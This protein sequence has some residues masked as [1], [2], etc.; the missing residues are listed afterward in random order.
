MFKHRAT[1]W[2]RF[3][4]FP[5]V[6]AMAFT[7]LGLLACG[8]SPTNASAGS[9][10]EVGTSPGDPSG[11]STTTPGDPPGGSTATPPAPAQLKLLLTDAPVNDAEAVYVNVI[12]TRIRFVPDPPADDGA[13]GAAQ[14]SGGAPADAGAGGAEQGSGGAPNA[15]ED[16]EENAEPPKGG[17]AAGD[18][19]GPQGGPPTYDA[20]AVSPEAGAWISVS[21][22]PATY[23]LLSLQNG[24]TA[25]L[26]NLT[27][28]A[29][30]VT[31]IRLILDPENQG[32]IVVAGQSHP[33]KV[34]SGSESG[35]KLQGMIP[36]VAGL[37][38]SITIDF[39]AAKSV[40]R[41]GDQYQLKPVVSI[42]GVTSEPAADEPAAEEPSAP[43]EP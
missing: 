20:P 30:T 14:G 36:L 2:A 41:A 38:T 13:G 11:G 26:G 18:G 1:A 22:A 37:S 31:G 42:A 4:A 3:G 16:P 43:S 28:A 19:G 8:E 17:P 29:G 33:L 34:P 9:P 24:V 6:C 7:S 15:P 39:D 12:E 27:L 32:S 25:A 21:A 23:E 35:L 10:G 5:A 40:I